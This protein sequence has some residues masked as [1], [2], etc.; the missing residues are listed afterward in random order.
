MLPPGRAGHY[1]QFVAEYEAVRRAEGRGA[2]KP[3][4]YRSLPYADLSG[5]S[6]RDWRIRAAG[7][8]TFVSKV[9]EPMELAKKRSLAVLDLGAGNGWLSYRMAKR[10]HVSAAVDLLVNRTDGLGAHV[11]YDEYFSAVQAEFDCLP[12]DDS[13]FDIAAFNSSFHYSVD[14]QAT[15]NEAWRVVK[16]G[17]HVVVI[18]SP[19]YSSGA[20]GRAMVVER[21]R[22]FTRKYGF[23]SNSI[24]SE[25]YLTFQ[26]LDELARSTRSEWR[27][28][29][30]RYDV[31]WR[32]R[33]VAARIRR[34]RE[35]AQFMVIVGD[36]A[37]ETW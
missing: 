15:L 29:R 11:N 17:G 4:Y 14:Y 18:D 27:L 34:R 16:P 22:E 23:P 36:R 6:S 25:G 12:F 5:R 2:S 24:A 32:L 7:F 30:P 37:R 13:E 10:G 26:R 1:S 20:S 28:H 33:S 35:P 9:V 31:R 19:V 3:E 21:E 8:Q